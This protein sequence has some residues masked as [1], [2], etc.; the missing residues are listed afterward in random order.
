VNDRGVP[1][2]P[3][4]RQILADRVGGIEMLCRHPVERSGKWFWEAAVPDLEHHVRLSEADPLA[5]PGP[6]RT[7]LEAACA[8]AV[9]E[10]LSHDRPLWEV[11]LVPHADGPFC[12]ILFR[13]HHALADGLAAE[14]VIAALADSGSASALV[15]GPSK[16]RAP[17]P[18]EARG[19]IRSVFDR[20][21][22]IAVQTA[23]V[24]RRTVR[25]KVLLGPLGAT[26]DVA[27]SDIR[28]SELHDGAE[29]LG[30]TVN[31]AFLAAF[32]QAIRAFLVTAREPLPETVPI[33]CPVRLDRRH[34]EGNATGVMLV[35]VPVRTPDPREAVSRVAAVTKTA[36]RHARAAGT[37]ELMTGPRAA[38]M[39]MRFARTQRAV[40]AIASDLPG[41]SRTLTLGGAELVRVW[42]LALLSANV[43]VGALGVSYAGR[44]RISLQTD[45]EHVPPARVLADAM[46]EA[47]K[48]IAEP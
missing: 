5:I 34:G 39:L 24:F 18:A 40:A 46:T 12:G 25:S 20:L 37:F 38:A 22:R 8:T 7:V 43:R 27:F 2:V 48:A 10:P 17:L 32:G 31:D 4:L 35:A 19:R 21:G 47:L 42:P 33:S 6:G 11:L 14:D 9:M 41:P 30:G 3:R 1:D 29:R 45:A 26:R 44:F 36:K 16:D 28:L 15:T 23:A 13:I